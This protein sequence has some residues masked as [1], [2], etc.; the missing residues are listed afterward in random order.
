MERQDSISNN[1][2]QAAEKDLKRKIYGYQ[3]PETKSYEQWLYVA[4]I[5]KQLN[6]TG[7]VGPV[8]K[9]F[10]DK[11]YTFDFFQPEDRT[12]FKVFER[13]TLDERQCFPRDMYRLMTI[14]DVKAYD[15]RVLPTNCWY[16]RVMAVDHE[17]ERSL[18]DV[19]EDNE[20]TFLFYDKEL[21]SFQQRDEQGLWIW[22]SVIPPLYEEGYKDA[23]A[24]YE[25][26][27]DEFDGEEDED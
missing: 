12:L 22:H 18:P 20:D 23:C 5:A 2:L 3:A 15:C 13:N 24:G 11:V 1:G 25:E 16:G 10:G 4:A 7:L 8:K 27:D 19:T 9:T 6:R 17:L 26:D 21:W 14:V